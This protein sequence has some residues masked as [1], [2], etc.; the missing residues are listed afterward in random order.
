[1]FYE[2]KR[3]GDMRQSRRGEEAKQNRR[4]KESGQ[5]RILDQRKGGF[6]HPEPAQ[7]GTVLRHRN[8]SSDPCVK[9]RQPLTQ[10]TC[11]LHCPLLTLMCKNTGSE[12]T[13]NNELG[14]QRPD[15]RSTKEPRRPFCL[16]G[17]KAAYWAQFTISLTLLLLPRD[18]ENQLLFP[19]RHHLLSK[20][21]L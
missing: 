2:D 7:I 18:P 9:S 5:N 11:W 12:Q 16:L 10:A 8:S 6:I 3:S 17:P 4:Q 20:L 21:W 15:H 19:C 14:F 13:E 1:M